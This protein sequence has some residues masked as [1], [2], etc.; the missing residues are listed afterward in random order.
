M[1]EVFTGLLLVALIG[2]GFLLARR[3][4]ARRNMMNAPM[5]M[6]W[7]SGYG[8]RDDYD[9]NVPPDQGYDGPGYNRP[10][11]GPGYGDPRYSRSAYGPGYDPAG[12]GRPMYGPGYPQ[13]SS[14]SPWAAGGLGAVGGGLLGYELGQMAG[15]HEQQAQEGDAGNPDQMA[16]L[17]AGGYDPGMAD[18]MGSYDVGGFSDVGGDFGAGDF[19]GIEM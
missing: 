13:Q 9:R 17:D 3:L 18:S 16:P 7:Q 8:P 19:G 2:G 15:E 1:I 12:Y 11:Y 4:F 5:E 10:M 14:M 6:P